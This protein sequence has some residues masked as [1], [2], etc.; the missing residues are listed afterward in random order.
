[1]LK[2]LIEK[3]L[4]AIILSPK[5]VATFSVC[6]ILI[7]LSIFVGIQEYR[8]A[9]KQYESAMQLTEQEMREQSSYMG[10]STR[11]YRKP[12]PMQIFVSGVHYDI[13][14]LSK[15]NSFDALKLTNSVYS[16]DPIYAIF[17]FIDFTFIV[18]IVLSLFAILFTYDA[19]NG[20]REDG[21]LKLI[22]ANAVPRAKYIM[23]KFV[24]S[25][26]GMVVPLLIPIL[27]GSLMVLLFNIP[28]SGE[29]WTK[30]FTL[31]GAS[32]L[33][34][35]FFIAL[36]LLISTMTNY[37]SVSFLLL[38]VAWV[39][40]VLIVPRAAVM[41]AG[42]FISVPSVAEIEGQ[43]DGFSKAKWTKFTEGMSERWH[44]RNSAMEG[45]RKED[46]EAYRDERMWEWMEEEDAARKKMQAEINDFNIKLQEELR[47]RKAEQER[48]AFSMSGLSRASALQLTAMNLASTN[49]N[50]K[51]RYEDAMQN[52]RTKFIEYKDKKQKESGQQGGIRITMDSDSGMKIDTGRDK[53]TLDI[54]DMPRF[55]APKSGFTD[56]LATTIID[57]GLLSLYTLAAFAGAFVVFLRYDVR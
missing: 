45:M 26:L 34:F 52:Y 54:S 2:T 13:G 15:I 16:D 4:R 8:A 7:L 44:G 9:V 31:L 24:G 5:F 18:Q 11:T 14:R 51:T 28:L 47:N 40:L 3:E 53:G 38:L 30:I 55:E 23:A 21:T 12:D 39:I 32:I 6:S 25:W 29:H 48:F 49:I 27:L 50:L 43:Q 35:T 57:F 46:R 36:G 22:F 19:I 17:R 56:T 20:E 1:M 10:L 42:Q 41:S 37:S 33:F